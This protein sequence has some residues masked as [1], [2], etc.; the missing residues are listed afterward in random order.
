MASAQTRIRYGCKA[1][2]WAYLAAVMVGSAQAD[3]DQGM[4]AYKHHDFQ[5]AISEFRSLAEIGDQRSQYM[6][7]RMYYE[8]R[9]YIWAYGWIKLAADAGFA[10][11]VEVE[12]AL[13]AA[14]SPEARARAQQLI[15][16]YSPAGIS[17][18][19]MPKIL[20]NCEYQGRTGPNLLAASGVYPPAALAKRIEGH[21]TVEVIVAADGRTRDARI[22]S[23]IPIGVFEDAA[24]RAARITSLPRATVSPPAPL[25]P[26][27]ST[28]RSV[29][30][31][32]PMAQSL[33]T[34]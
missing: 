6:L 26:S 3:F 20:P 23:A 7:G 17:Q 21:V 15:A 4:E 12:K 22:L 27:Q 9:N 10:Q 25:Q 14:L 11:A 30:A 32:R 34:S 5:N 19:L 2:G 29:R 16:D 33:P 31:S 1:A 24:R 13:G 28:L 18:R 8:A